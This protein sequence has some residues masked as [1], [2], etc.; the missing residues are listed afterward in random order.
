MISIVATGIFWFSS[1]RIVSAAPADLL[2]QNGLDTRQPV[3]LTAMMAAHQK[4]NMREHL[5]AVQRII[6]ALQTGNL[7]AVGES[8]KEMGFSPQMGQMC[9]MMGAATPGFAKIALKFHHT[10]DEIG[11]AAS[12]RDEPVVLSALAKTLAIC[13]TCHAAYVQKVVSD[14]AWEKWHASPHAD[15]FP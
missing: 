11:A 5:M 3:Y 2:V 9:E 15:R 12:K 10:A 8:A 4:E 14:E 6:A 13:T 1:I 7:V